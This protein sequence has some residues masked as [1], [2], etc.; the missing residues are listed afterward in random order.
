MPRQI[1]AQ[2]TAYPA[3]G[4]LALAIALALA[5]SG[6]ARAGDDPGPRATDLDAVH[7]RVSIATRTERLLSDAPVRIEVLRGEE[8]A[9]R[10]ALDFSQAADLI[11]GLRVGS[12]GQNCH[13]SE[14]QLLGLP[15]AYNQLRFDGTPLLSTLGSVYGREQIPAAFIDTVEVVKGGGSSAPVGR[16]G[17]MPG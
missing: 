8:I 13:T 11:N 12:N 14:A 1:S 7:V 15:G 2:S 9:L 4:S 17:A 6:T 3:G 16:A 5:A 10:A